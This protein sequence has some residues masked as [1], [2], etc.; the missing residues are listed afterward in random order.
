MRAFLIVMALLGL[1]GCITVP[2]QIKGDISSEH[3]GVTFVKNGNYKALAQYWDEKA[4]KKDIEFV[5]ASF[6]GILEKEQKA[7]ITIGNGPYYGLIELEQ[8]DQ[9]QTRVTYHAWG[10]LAYKII[11]WAE[12]IRTSPEY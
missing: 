3:D 12:L 11:D 5:G 2:T 6:L 7:E 10:D 1:S 8:V 4:D 9:E